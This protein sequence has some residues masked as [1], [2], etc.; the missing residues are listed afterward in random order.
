MHGDEHEARVREQPAQALW[1][2]AELGWQDQ[3]AN[4]G[5]SIVVVAKVQTLVNHVA[6]EGLRVVL[7]QS[8]CK[9]TWGARRV[10]C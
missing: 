8:T 3:P 7:I 4:L 2:P 9:N 5:G 1:V 10:P 6:V